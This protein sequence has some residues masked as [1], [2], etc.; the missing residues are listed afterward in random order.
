[1]VAVSRSSS[2]VDLVGFHVDLVRFDVTLVR[3]DAHMVVHQSLEMTIAEVN[4]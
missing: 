1:M 3:S 2:D 4:R